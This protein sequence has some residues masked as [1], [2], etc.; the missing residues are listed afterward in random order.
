MKRQTKNLLKKF[1]QQ[2]YKISLTQRRG[3]KVNAIKITKHWFPLIGFYE[4]RKLQT[5]AKIEVE[6]HKARARHSYGYNRI[7]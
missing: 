4:T 1:N 2:Q 3:K 6:R 7:I 5:I